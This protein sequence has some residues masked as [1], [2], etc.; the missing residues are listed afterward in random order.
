MLDVNLDSNLGLNSIAKEIG[1]MY[2]MVSIVLAMGLNLKIIVIDWMK[3]NVYQN[4][5]FVD[6]Y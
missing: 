4:V 2:A 5:N 1:Y 6:L 3:E